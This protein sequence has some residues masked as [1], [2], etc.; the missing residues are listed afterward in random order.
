MGIL[1]AREIC[2][3]MDEFSVVDAL[4]AIACGFLFAILFSI[5]YCF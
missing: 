1:I 3:T 5:V 4:F 2:R